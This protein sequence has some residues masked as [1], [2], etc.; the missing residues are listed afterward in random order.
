[1]A[2]RLLFTESDDGVKVTDI[3]ASSKSYDGCTKEF[4]SYDEKIEW[5]A[6]AEGKTLVIR[7]TDNG[8]VI[9][10]T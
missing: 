4:D 2:H 8:L 3:S 7:D 5:L 10:R 9:A 6:E 1:M